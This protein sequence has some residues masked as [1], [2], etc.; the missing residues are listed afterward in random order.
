MVSLRSHFIKT[1]LHPLNYSAIALILSIAFVYSLP[2]WIAGGIGITATYVWLGSNHSRWWTLIVLLI[3][4]AGALNY[5]EKLADHQAFIARLDNI[6]CALKGTVISI[7][8]Q[9]GAR[10]RQK[11]TIQTESFLDAQGVSFFAQKTILIYL[12]R[13]TNVHVAD[14]IEIQDFCLKKNKNESYDQYL[15]KESIATTVFLTSLD[16]KLIHRP[17]F[18]LFRSLFYFKQS[19]LARCKK[20]LSRPS[21][22]FFASVFLGNKSYEK[23]YME[24]PK[25]NCKTW[26]ISHYLA[27]SGLHMVIFICIWFFLLNLLPISFTLKQI[28]LIIIGLVYHYLSWPSISFLRALISFLLFKSCTLLQ[29]SSHLLHLLSLVTIGVLFNNPM[30]LFFLDFQLSFGLTFALA[31][32][33]NVATQKSH[34]T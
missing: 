26:G 21:F 28:I 25:D 10:T 24:T 19:I 23:K 11:I 2:L 4:A 30:Q 6:Q 27:R 13:P 16:Y 17:S 22:A 5:H 33:N 18:S 12:S 14:Y 32:F 34:I 7:E 15:I 20:K 9:D 29:V 31:W 3:Y 1:Q 8:S